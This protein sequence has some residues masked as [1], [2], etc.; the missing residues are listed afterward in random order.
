[1]A[2]G[3]FAAR[4]Q[5]AAAHNAAS[6]QGSSARGEGAGQGQGHGYSATGNAGTGN[7]GSKK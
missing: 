3:G 7:G 6:I 4:A 1:M 5:R 2:S